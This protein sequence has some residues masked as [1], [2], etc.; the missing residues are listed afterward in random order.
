[1][2]HSCQTCTDYTCDRIGQDMRGCEHHTEEDE[3]PRDGQS[4]ADAVLAQVVD[5][6]EKLA[7]QLAELRGEW[8]AVCAAFVRA[9]AGEER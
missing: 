2:T 7:Q 6:I 1:M 3:L 9:R 5:D 8:D 4:P